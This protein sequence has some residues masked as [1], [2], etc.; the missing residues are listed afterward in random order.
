MEQMWRTGRQHLPTPGHAASMA[1]ISRWQFRKHVHGPKN[2]AIL[3][4]V[5]EPSWSGPTNIHKTL[6]LGT[7]LEQDNN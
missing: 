6:A 7:F 4:A 1:K 2:L 3:P 5:I